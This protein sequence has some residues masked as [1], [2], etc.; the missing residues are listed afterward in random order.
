MFA[1]LPFLGGCG[2]AQPAGGNGGLQGT[3]SRG[4]ITPTCTPGRSCSAPAKGVTLV[5]S[6]GGSVV[7]RV[8]TGSDGGY[9]VALPAGRYSVGGVKFLRP[10]QVRVPSGRSRHM[11]FMIDTRIR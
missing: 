11:N 9:R 4:P 1:S 8:K 5:F 2:G 6:R 3:V 10:V 7:A